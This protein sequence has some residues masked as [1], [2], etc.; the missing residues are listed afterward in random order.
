MATFVILTRNGVADPGQ[1]QKLIDLATELK[2]PDAKLLLHLHGGLIDKDTG[3]DI[4]KRLS[5][6]TADS[7]KLGADWTQVYVVWRTGI[8]ETIETN[9]TDLVHDDRLYQTIVRKLIGFVARRLGI[10]SIATRGPGTLAISDADIHSRLTGR[11]KPRP[12]DDFDD[13]LVPGLPAGSRATIMAEQS[14]GDMAIDFQKDLAEDLDFQSATADIDEAVNVPSGARAPSLGANQIN[15][16]KMRKRLNARIRS[17]LTAPPAPA[18]QARGI[19]SVGTF[20]LTHAGKVAIRCF[21]RFRSGRDHGLHATIVE[22]VCREFYGDLVG[23]KA[24]GMMVQDAADHFTVGGL[25]TALIDIVKANPPANF[26]I[27]G[28]SAG[29]I[30]ASQFLLAAKASDFNQKVKLFL[31]APAV[32]ETLFA[33]VLDQ[34]GNL[35]ESCLMITMTDELE[36][37]DAVLGHDKT[38]IYPSSLLYVVSGMFEE[39][40]AK[41]YPDAPILGMQ[42]FT[43]LAGLS[44]VE[45][46]AAK[47]IADFFQGAKH[48]IISS[49]TAGVSM[50]DTHGGFDDEPLTLATARALF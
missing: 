44:D 10:P 18:G 15:G 8:F 48:G 6:A 3:S 43:S 27:V 33:E 14:S 26:V 47:K 29:S 49:P 31:L 28:H 7:W 40:G 50:A 25:G 12:F 4:A 37:K 16:E 36:R 5:G 35:I 2:K 30:W 34:A 13:L 19:I 24:W 23:A 39:L 20:L 46:V 21:K 45:A 42:R 9:W 22:E 17:Q 11:G 32:R 38:Y 41:P 1:E